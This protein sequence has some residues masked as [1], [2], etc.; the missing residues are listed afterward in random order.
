MKRWVRHTL[1]DFSALSEEKAEQV[2][3]LCS[4]FDSLGYV[5]FMSHVGPNQITRITDRQRKTQ[6]EITLKA[7]RLEE[8]IKDL[9]KPDEQRQK[10]EREREIKELLSRK[11]QIENHIDFIKRLYTKQLASN[12]P[13]KAKTTLKLEEDKLQTIVNRLNELQ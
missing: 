1:V 9:I 12:R 3:Q 8:Q 4:E 7:F 10:E 11:R 2:K 6:S 13:N 5:D